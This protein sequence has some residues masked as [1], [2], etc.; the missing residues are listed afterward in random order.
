MLLCHCKVMGT[1]TRTQHSYL[2]QEDCELEASLNHTV[3]P[4]LRHTQ[5]HTDTPTP[6]RETHTQF[7]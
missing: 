1:T 4:S 6:Q 3:R 2:R 5:K 7:C